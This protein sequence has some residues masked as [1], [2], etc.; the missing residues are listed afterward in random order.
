[1][2]VYIALTA[3]TAGIA[4]GVKKEEGAPGLTRRRLCN[5]ILLTAIFLLLFAVSACRRYVGNDYGRYLE[6]FHLI[7]LGEYVPTEFGFNWTVRVM[8]WIFGTD[9]Q[10]PIFALFAFATIFLM[11]KA[12]YAQSECFFFSFT[13]FM[14]LTYYFQSLNTVRYYFVLAVAFYAAKYAIN[15]QYAKFIL[16]VLA[17]APIHKSVLLVIPLYILANR[18]WKKSQ[19]ACM[20]LLACSGLLFGDLYLKLILYVY[21][22][23]KKTLYLEGGTSVVNIVRCAG[24]LLLSLLFYKEA[25]KGNRQNTFFFQLNILALL[26]Y[27]CCSFLPEISRIGYYMTI[28][29]VFLIPSVILKIP[30]VWMRRCFQAAAAAAGILYFAVFLHKASDHLL[31]IVPY[32][33]WILEADVKTLELPQLAGER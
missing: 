12:L 27:A 29:H 32:Q 10:L 2:G 30:R 20:V 19:I 9:T 28:G 24:V 3:V 23:Y 16:L 18:E 25:V 21:P 1:M 11:L 26:L 6:F 4:A 13:L 33:T 22:S 5:A 15:R 31:R 17:A 8:Q 14:L 7:A